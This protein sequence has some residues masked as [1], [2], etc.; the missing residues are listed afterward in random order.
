MDGWMKWQDGQDRWDHGMNHMDGKDEEE[1][2]DEFFSFLYFS[3]FILLMANTHFISLFYF[4]FCFQITISLHSLG[5]SRRGGCNGYDTIQLLQPQSVF[6]I[7]VYL[8]LQTDFSPFTTTPVLI[9]L[10]LHNRKRSSVLVGLKVLGFLHFFTLLAPPWRS[11]C[12]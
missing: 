10:L 2:D 9:P 6:S 3:L 12:V 1:I 4:Y 11:Y 7:F 8:Y 5:H